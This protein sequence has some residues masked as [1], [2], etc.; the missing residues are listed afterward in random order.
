MNKKT[1]AMWAKKAAEADENRNKIKYWKE[2]QK[3]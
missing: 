2:K 3:L 1:L